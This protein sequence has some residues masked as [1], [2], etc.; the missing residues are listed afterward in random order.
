MRVSSAL[1]SN[2]LGADIGVVL[3]CRTWLTR[4]FPRTTTSLRRL[5]QLILSNPP[6][7]LEGGLLLCLHVVSRSIARRG[8][9]PPPMWQTLIRT[10]RTY[11]N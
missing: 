11:L 1:A 2:I 5:N 8:L 4:T 3:Q 6:S 9:L 7:P 10:F